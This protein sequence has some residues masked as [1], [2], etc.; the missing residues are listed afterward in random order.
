MPASNATLG[1]ESPRRDNTRK[2]TLWRSPGGPHRGPGRPPRRRGRGACRSGARRPGGCR[3]GGGGTA[4][5]GRYARRTGDGR[6]GLLVCSLSR[7]RRHSPTR[8]AAVRTDRCAKAS[9]DL[10]GLDVLAGTRR[11][12]QRGPY[13]RL[14]RVSGNSVLAPLATVAEARCD[15][16]RGSQ[17]EQRRRGP[18]LP[19]RPTA[20]SVRRWGWN[21]LP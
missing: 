16:R 9:L 14:S 3:S 7:T 10:A 13:P 2:R 1:V 11:A 8:P 6:T 17:L 12:T 19:W 20:L 5:F 4:A 15:A 21:S 18:P